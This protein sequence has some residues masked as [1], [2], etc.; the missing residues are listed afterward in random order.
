M[1]IIDLNYKLD[2]KGIDVMLGCAANH[3]IKE[4]QEAIS[5]AFREITVSIEHDSEFGICR[6]VAVNNRPL[7]ED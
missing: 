2:Q 5:D 4:H 3:Y 7:V 1:P 6:L